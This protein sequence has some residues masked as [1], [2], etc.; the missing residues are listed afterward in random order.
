MKKG[1]D[2]KKLMAAL[3]EDVESVEVEVE[4]GEGEDDAAEMAGAVFDALQEGDRE[5]FVDAF[6]GLLG[7]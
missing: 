2:A 6:L 4:G 5:S 3:P 7:L 1:L